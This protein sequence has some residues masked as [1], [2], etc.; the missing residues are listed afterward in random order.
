MMNQT[1]NPVNGQLTLKMRLGGSDR[2]PRPR[3]AWS[4][5]ESRVAQ[6]PNRICEEK[7]GDWI[8]R[9]QPWIFCTRGRM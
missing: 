1:A 5:L 3:D 4:K 2:G 7:Y 6:P 8:I 9:I